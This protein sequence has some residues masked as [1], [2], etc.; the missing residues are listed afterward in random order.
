MA[1]DEHG[2][3]A[4]SP[5]DNATSETVTSETVSAGLLGPECETEWLE[6]LGIAPASDDVKP[7]QRKTWLPGHVQPEPEK[8][9][10]L[11]ATIVQ[12]GR[13]CEAGP[14][15]LI[16][17]AAAT[18]CN[19]QRKERNDSRTTK[20]LTQQGITLAFLVMGVVGSMPRWV[21]LLACG[22]LHTPSDISSFKSDWAQ[23]RAEGTV[24]PSPDRGLAWRVM[25]IADVGLNAIGMTSASMALAYVATEHTKGRVAR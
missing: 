8:A 9:P 13:D 18:P 25:S 23:C 22:Q 5:A 21:T 17:C 14:S 4:G 19:N 7:A 11:Q 12:A 24:F 15:E 2:V 16:L 3:R 20:R 6:C 1:E 10:C